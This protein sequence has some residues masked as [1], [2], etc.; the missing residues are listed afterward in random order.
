MDA[1]L[2]IT[3]LLTGLTRMAEFSKVIAAARAEGRDLTPE[4][5]AAAGF[6][7]QDALAALDAKLKAKE[8][9]PG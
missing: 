2:A 9:E 6:T 5:V 3:L 1:N 8:G 7:A 4:E